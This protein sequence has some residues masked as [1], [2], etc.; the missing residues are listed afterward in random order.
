MDSRRDITHSVHPGMSELRAGEMITNFNTRGHFIGNPV[1]Q[2]DLNT[3]KKE[4]EE[5]EAKMK[6][7]NDDIEQM[8]IFAFSNGFQIGS[9][10]AI[11]SISKSSIGS[12]NSGLFP[13][14]ARMSMKEFFTTKEGD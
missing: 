12:L 10:K 3:I 5:L 2:V 11:E 14:L 13:D 7:M 9:E 1:L 8:F 6:A 4:L